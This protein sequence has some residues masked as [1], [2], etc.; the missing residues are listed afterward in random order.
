MSHLVGIVLYLIVYI[1]KNY[2][3]IADLGSDIY[4]QIC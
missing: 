1:T 2:T 3:I 4:A